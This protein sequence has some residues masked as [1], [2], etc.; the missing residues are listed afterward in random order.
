MGEF[1]GRRTVPTALE[2][3]IAFLY[4]LVGVTYLITFDTKRAHLTPILIG[5]AGSSKG[6]KIIC[7]VAVSHHPKKL[8]LEKEKGRLREWTPYPY[9]S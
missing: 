5:G 3:R 6:I 8:S 2:S 7:H 1:R 9:R 4:E